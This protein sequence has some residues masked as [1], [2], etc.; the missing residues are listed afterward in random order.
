MQGERHFGRCARLSCG[1]DGLSILPKA[2]NTAVREGSTDVVRYL[3]EKL[4]APIDGV[5]PTL[6]ALNPS[7][8]LLQVLVDRGFDMDKPNDGQKQLGRG[9]Y[10]LQQLCHHEELVRWCLD[11]GAKVDGMA[12]DANYSPPLM[13]SVAT[14]GSV[15]TFKFLLSKGAK[16]KGRILH[17]AAQNVGSRP[18]EGPEVYQKRLA[19]LKYLMDEVGI[20]VNAIDSTKMMGNFWGSPIVY[21]SK[22]G[23]DSAEAVNIFLERGASPAKDV[24]FSEA[25]RWA[26]QENNVAVVKVLE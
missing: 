10:L 24:T 4:H 9:P 14:F 21:A 15:S 11:H 25:L 16:L 19:M 17:K 22:S 12:V 2:L 23:F 8:K 5:R 3:L 1:E 6:V 20:D 13:E 26:K 18:N 7:T